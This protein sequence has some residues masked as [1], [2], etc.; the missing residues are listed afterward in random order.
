MSARRIAGTAIL[1][2]LSLIAFLIESLFPPL[3][4]PGAKLGLGN[5]FVLI[6]LFYYGGTN[7]AIVLLVKLLLGN[8]LTGNLSALM[9]GLPAGAFALTAE[10]LLARFVFPR[11]SVVA[12]S[13][14][15]ACLSNAVQT[16]VF[17][18]VIRSYAALS[19]LPYLV[20]LGILSGAVVGIALY[21]ILKFLP[22]RE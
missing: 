8:L 18:L 3:V 5:L 19:Y 15:G 2:A 22:R 10:Y 14:F 17:A 13:V 4:L 12:I 7:A 11:V 1:A 9:Y 21:F 20:L 6:A 16:A